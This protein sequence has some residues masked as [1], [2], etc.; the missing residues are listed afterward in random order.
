M[1]LTSVPQPVKSDRPEELERT[2]TPHGTVRQV[3]SGIYVV[4][5]YVSSPS[6]PPLQAHPAN[7]Q[8]HPF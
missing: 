8:P 2:R 6:C 3:G 5:S 4:T 7:K 1:W